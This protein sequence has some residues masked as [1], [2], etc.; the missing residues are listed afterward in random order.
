MVVH[1]LRRPR[2]RPACR[3]VRTRRSPAGW[4]G[5]RCRRSGA[6]SRSVLPSTAA[7]SSSAPACCSVRLDRSRLPA[8]FRAR[9]VAMVSVPLRTW[10]TMPTRL[11]FMWRR[12][13]SRAPVSSCV[14]ASMRAG[15][16]AGG[17]GLG[18]VPPRRGSA[19]RCRASAARHER[20]RAAGAG[21]RAGRSGV[22][23]ACASASMAPA[24]ASMLAR[25]S[26]DQVLQQVLV[27][28][29]GRREHL[30]EDARGFVRVA[31]GLGLDG[32]VARGAV[33]PCA[34]RGSART[35]PFLGP[36]AAIS[37][38]ICLS[39]SAASLDRGGRVFLE[40]GAERRDRCS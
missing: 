36:L 19:A 21:G 38:S 13:R 15:Q 39:S 26:V 6:R 2:R 20:R 25:C 14:C 30:V 16:V 40:V 9:R 11:S 35:A 5:A 33:Q 7:V 24:V 4:P 29:G 18:H 23:L 1:H 22:V 8:R 34:A 27:F 10:P 17:H 3:D 31:V 28:L 32:A 37:G 12:A